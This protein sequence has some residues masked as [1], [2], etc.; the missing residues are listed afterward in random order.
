MRSLAPLHPPFLLMSDTNMSPAAIEKSNE[1]FDSSM[2]TSTP[3]A[4]PTSLVADRRKYKL[5]LSNLPLS[6]VTKTFMSQY[7]PALLALDNASPLPSS[8]IHLAKKASNVKHGIVTF[9]DQPSCDKFFAFFK[10]NYLRNS[11][12][13]PNETALSTTRIHTSY[14]VNTPLVKAAK[15]TAFT[16]STSSR[17]C[18]VISYEVENIEHAKRKQAETDGGDAEKKRKESVLMTDD[19]ARDAITNQWRTYLCPEPEPPK[20]KPTETTAS[21]ASTPSTPATPAPPARKAYHLYCKTNQL[22][23]ACLTKV[24][25]EVRGEY[26]KKIEFFN[27]VTRN[28]TLPRVLLEKNQDYS[29]YWSS[30]TPDQR[31]EYKAKW[32]KHGLT[33]PLDYPAWT[34]KNARSVKWCPEGDGCVVASPLE[35]FYRNKCELTFGL[36]RDAKTALGFLPGG[37][38]GAVAHPAVCYNVPTITAT[39]SD[40]I[41]TVVRASDA[42]HYEAGVHGGFW[43]QVTV[44]T[45]NESPDATTAGSIQVV[46]QHAKAKGGVT[47]TGPDFSVPFD[48]AKLALESALCDRLFEVDE[49]ARYAEVNALNPLFVNDA[50]EAIAKYSRSSYRVSSLV[51]QEFNDVSMP[52]PS[53]PTQTHKGD[54]FIMQR[55]LNCRFK[56]SSEREREARAAAS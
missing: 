38:K 48:A 41:Q 36:D 33:L 34:D 5:R 10:A 52:S 8:A 24:L 46:I 20:P 30:L 19:G 7:M 16:P 26:R 22:K 55:I 2:D 39:I 53:H 54:D 32:A 43:R 31:T 6:L 25:T 18:L 45:S 11:P 1:T 23:K 3:P 50:E 40:A 44:R 4:P 15:L 37:W 14:D 27:K 47:G 42:P 51:F 49:S 28:K 21:T 56:V 13:A 9:S 12:S 35:S 29:T 17:D